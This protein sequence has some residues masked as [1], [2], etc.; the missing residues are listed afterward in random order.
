M[1]RSTRV[2]VRQRATRPGNVKPLIT[3]AATAKLAAKHFIEME[4]AY[5]ELAKLM[6]KGDVR[7]GQEGKRKA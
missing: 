3:L 2:R 4:K 1:K 6:V 5:K 7:L